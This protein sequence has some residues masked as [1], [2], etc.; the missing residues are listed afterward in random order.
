[1]TAPP[2]RASRAAP[3]RFSTIRRRAIQTAAGAVPRASAPPIAALQRA[4]AVDRAAQ[5]TNQAPGAASRALASSSKTGAKKLNRPALGRGTSRSRPGSSAAERPA[6]RHAARKVAPA[7]A[8]YS[9]A[10]AIAW[11]PAVPSKKVALSIPSRVVM[12]PGTGTKSTNG[13]L[14][15]WVSCCQGSSTSPKWKW[16]GNRK[17]IPEGLA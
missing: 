13:A 7:E 14:P 6:N 9:S 15:K 3:R 16:S 17:G 2:P 12:S 4:S 10:A 5:A 8:P 1:M 11:V